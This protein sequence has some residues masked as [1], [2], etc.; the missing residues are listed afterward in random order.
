MTSRSSYSRDRGD[1]MDR[2]QRQ[3]RM[4][5]F[6]YENRGSSQFDSRR[7]PSDYY[8]GR[9]AYGQD[10]YENASRNQYDRYNRDHEH[11]YF[12]EDYEGNRGFQGNYDSHADRDSYG[13]QSQSRRPYD[14]EYRAYERNQPSQR[15]GRSWES[16]SNDYYTER[17][18]RQNHGQDYGQN[19]QQN[20]GQGYG[21]QGY[22]GQG[23]GSQRYDSQG[24]G[25]QSYGSQGN[26]QNYGGRSNQNYDQGGYR[27]EYS[28]NT[29]MNNDNWQDQS[30]RESARRRGGRLNNQ[31]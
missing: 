26:R 16:D 3:G 1:R 17:G 13:Q 23:T 15:M 12:D 10:R 6:N 29:N 8:S 25:G 14:Q 9:G 31:Y 28:A 4:N 27:Q 11:R 7:E 22:G 24:Y 19:Y 18:D 5:E 20:Y 21:N 30:Y 2:N